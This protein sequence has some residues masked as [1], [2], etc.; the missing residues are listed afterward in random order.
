LPGEPLRNAFGK[1]PWVAPVAAI[2]DG[3]AV[4]AIAFGV[5]G[6][7]GMG[8]FQLHTGLHV[9]WGVPLD[10]TLVSTLILLALVVAY[11]A[12][13]STSLDKGIQW[14]SNINM[15]VALLLL[16]FVLAAGPTAQLLRG[17]VTSIGDYTAALVGISLR[18][19]PYHKARAWLETWTLTYF[20]WWIAWAPFVGVF[21]ARI[22]RGRTIKEFV[23]G[24]LFVPTVFSVL[25]FGVFGGTGLDEE[26]NGAGGI[27]R[28]VREDVSVALF[29]LFD[30]LPLSGLLSGT[31]IVLVFIF[32]VTSVDSATFVLGMLTSRGS[33]DPPT[34]RKLAWGLS[35]GALGGALM[36]TG[37]VDAV[38]AVAVLGAL[39]FAFIMLLQIAAL[40]R[41]FAREHR[42]K[43]PR[44]AASEPGD[45]RSESTHDPE[46]T[47]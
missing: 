16:V 23:L 40:L 26:L 35:L 12:S 31:A 32:L 14:L 11:T 10:S 25:W 13:A 29:S 20:L 30:R 9:L 4:L 15:V 3:V 8:I 38:R 6:S 39:P 1:R 2:A 19:Y 43:P 45:D 5:A 17:F 36:L 24:V 28:L 41:V 37:N 47:P 18:L 33:L 34:R 7:L 21:I 46:G 27:A 44:V 22:S 42:R